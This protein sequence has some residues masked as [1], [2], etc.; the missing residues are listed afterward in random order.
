[1]N[2]KN[3][4]VYIRAVDISQMLLKVFSYIE[5]IHHTTKDILDPFQCS[6][7]LI[8]NNTI[9]DPLRYILVCS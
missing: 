6:I 2:F 9:F 5:C 8:H 4:T 1:M 3:M 7:E